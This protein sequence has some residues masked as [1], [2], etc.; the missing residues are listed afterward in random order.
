VSL[1]PKPLII[2]EKPSAARA[3]A[4]ALGG[5]ARREGY[6]E[7]D[8]YRLSWAI[9]HLVELKGPEEYDPAFKRWSLA[10]LPILPERFELKVAQRTRAQF[11]LLARLVKAATEVINACDAG[12]EGELI[13]RY[14]YTLAGGRAPVRRLWTSA[15][16]REAIRKA[17]REMKPAREY[18][19]LYQSALCRAQGDWLVGM[20]ATRAFTA[21]WGELLSVGR[22]QTPTLSLLVRREEEI[23]R[24]RPEAY[25]EVSAT[26]RTREGA[27][28]QGLWTGPTG[29]RL[30]SAE[31]AE[32]I[33]RKVK[34]QNGQVQK[35]ETKEEAE[36]P[37]LL[38]DLTSL[39]REANRRFGLTAAAT[40]K[41]AQSLYE[42]KHIT[43]P[44]T[45][46]RYITKDLL[47]AFPRV[48]AVLESDPLL[49]D[50][51]KGANLDLVGPGNRRVVD[52]SKVTDHHAIL[53]TAEVPRGL[54][55]VEAKIYDLI[56]RRFLAQFYP[57]A[58][59]AIAE[60]ITGV[61][62]ELFRSRGKQLLQPGW[63]QVEGA[64][65]PASP[66]A[67]KGSDEGESDGPPLPPLQTGER[68]AVAEAKSTRKETQPPKRYSEATL[69]A[70]MEGAG[71]EL[72][73][74]A[75]KAAMKGRG[76]GTPAT[77]AAIIERLKEVGYIEVRQKS[78]HPTPKARR[79]LR[80]AEAA[81]AEALLSAELTGEW[82][83]RIAD[84]QA[85]SYAPDRLL[86]EIRQLTVGIVEGV[87]RAA[88]PA[89]L[90]AGGAANPDGAAE[91]RRPAD[92][93]AGPAGAHPASAQPASEV[94]LAAEG[95]L[96]AGLCPTCGRPVL[97]QGRDWRCSG[98]C[99]LRIPTWLCG[100]PIDRD[101]AEQLLTKG[102]S[103]LISNF[104]SPRTGKAFKAYLVLQAGK[105]AFEFPPD[106]PRKAPGGQRSG[107]KRER[108][109]AAKAG[110]RAAG[111]GRVRSTGGIGLGRRSSRASES[112]GGGA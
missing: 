75:L 17:W 111:H 33:L 36:R 65:G 78:L 93:E 6:L 54:A 57:D 59:W 92:A 10:T 19:R 74:E 95:A 2:A 30:P 89:D 103:K 70:A 24:F 27:L 1:A 11:N 55:G 88:T 21:R 15:L 9:G 108:A 43:Y 23:E 14:I 91:M 83:K 49:M 110:S 86:A 101:V 12:R 96:P 82:E 73:D 45:D 61:E 38:F 60:A 18:D 44:R 41:A 7:S 68:V 64:P 5:F 50:V 104:T 90:P 13:F 28:Y 109:T 72:D 71:K 37:P 25:W 16:T 34:G 22:V 40:L 46:S 3:I 39:Q 98:D 48:L 106:R 53:P 81:G 66:R 76:L 51:A 31:A 20:N 56:V 26:F 112:A 42:G 47:R 62:G 107:A 32:A 85:G 52:E 99:E 79:L 8:Q 69:L 4:E 87:K 67:R 35:V 97:K 94:D 105:V 63:R 102:K 77:R 100:R 84:I 58:R 29:D 80:L